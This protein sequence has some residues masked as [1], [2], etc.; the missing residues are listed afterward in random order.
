[1]RTLRD[2]EPVGVLYDHY[3]LAIADLAA[4]A[5]LEPVLRSFEIALLR[6]LG[7]ELVFD[8]DAGTGENVSAQGWYRHVRDLGFEAHRFVVRR[9]HANH[10]HSTWRCAAAGTPTSMP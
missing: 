5:D 2:N 9:A 10:G 1:M 7:Y 3:E 4:G 6:E 8:H